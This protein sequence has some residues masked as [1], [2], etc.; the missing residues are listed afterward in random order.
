MEKGPRE[1]LDA[2]SRAVAQGLVEEKSISMS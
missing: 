1:T 2:L